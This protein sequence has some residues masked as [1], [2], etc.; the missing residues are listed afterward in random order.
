MFDKREDEEDKRDEANIGWNKVKS[1]IKSFSQL[2]V[3][4]QTHNLA[5][6]S[7]FTIPQKPS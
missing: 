3:C 1:F 5:K 7:S 2:K 6:K 4:T